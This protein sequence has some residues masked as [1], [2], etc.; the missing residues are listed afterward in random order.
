[1]VV[2]VFA[3]TGVLTSLLSVPK[4]EPIVNTVDDLAEGGK[5]RITIEKN[6]QTSREFL[7]GL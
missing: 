5:L 6:T 4:L 1:M 3:Y 2:L 7:V